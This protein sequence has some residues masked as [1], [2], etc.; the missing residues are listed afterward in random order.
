VADY[1]VDA[2]L[3]LAALPLVQVSTRTTIPV[4]QTNLM[5]TINL[6]EAVKEN[7]WA[8]KDIRFLYFGSDKEYGPVGNQPYT[9]DM[10]I[11]PQAIY[12]CSKAAASFAVRAYAASKFIPA[13]IVT[14]SCN[15]IAPGDLNL[16][17]VLPRTIV[18]AIRDESP[19][20]YYT[21]Y[22]REFM[23]VAD[24]VEGALALDKELA[25]GRGHGE[26]FNLGSGE[27]RTIEQSVAEVL[28]YF[29]K[30][31]QTWIKPPNLSR[32]EIPF[33]KLDCKKVYNFCGW[34]AKV[35]FE[36]TVEQ[37]VKWW[38]DNWERLPVYVRNWRATG[39]HG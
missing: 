33:Q 38:Q 6:L 1:A 35:T 13:A 31:T 26:I 19:I 18:P 23:A 37:L 9:E 39:W 14:R 29:P 5:G 32:I 20:L 4:F 25:E 7:A 2:I 28:K 34:R 17:R 15:L 24:G 27:Q 11:N 10:P 8:G 12:E 16:G 21:E 3:H 30:V 36:Q 22:L